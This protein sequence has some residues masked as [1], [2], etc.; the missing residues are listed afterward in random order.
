MQAEIPLIQNYDIVNILIYASSVLIIK[1]TYSDMTTYTIFTNSGNN[2][3]SN[4][5]LKCPLAEIDWNV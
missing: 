1:Y 4:G 5:F 2:G 3:I